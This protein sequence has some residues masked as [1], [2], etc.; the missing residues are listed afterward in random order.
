MCKHRPWEGRLRHV[1]ARSGSRGAH[2][3]INISGGFLARGP[4]LY[5]ALPTPH[6]PPREKK[7][8]KKNWPLTQKRK[9]LS[10]KNLLGLLRGC[11]KTVPGV[12]KHQ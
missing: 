12:V 4:L 3:E 11:Y 1:D 5:V 10:I 8:E 7:N 6:P 2:A 9:V